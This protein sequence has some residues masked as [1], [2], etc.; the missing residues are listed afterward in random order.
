MYNTL[1]T[2]INSGVLTI[3]LNRPEAL[4]ALKSAYRLNMSYTLILTD[5]NMPV[6]T[7]IESTFQMRSYL[8]DEL[9]IPKDE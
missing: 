3:T 1:I 5:F 2:N 4:N 6:M 9:N 7:G 8:T